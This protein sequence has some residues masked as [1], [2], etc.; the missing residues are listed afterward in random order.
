MKQKIK[1]TWKKLFN[2]N[3][4]YYLKEIYYPFEGK[5]YVGYVI[6]KGYL[7]LGF[8]GYDKVA[9]C[10]DMDEVNETITRLNITLT[11]E[12]SKR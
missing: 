1:D 9:Y 2:T 10:Y 5:T 11:P 8:F 7:F 12:L 6:C 4:G 3:V